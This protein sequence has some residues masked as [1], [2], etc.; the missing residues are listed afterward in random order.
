[1]RIRRSVGRVRAVS[2]SAARNTQ[3]VISSGAA[4]CTSVPLNEARIDAPATRSIASTATPTG[5]TREN[6]E[7]RPGEVARLV[8]TAVQVQLACGS[9]FRD[10]IAGRRGDDGDACVGLA[11]RGDLRLSEM[12]RADNDAGAAGEF[13]EDW[14]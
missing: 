4:T 8:G 9:L 2:A 12:A 6:S 5:S 3:A 13:E 1:M 11:E 14:K 10:G 7:D